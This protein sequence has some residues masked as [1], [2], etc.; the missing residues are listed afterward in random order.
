MYVTHS[1]LASYANAKVNLKRD[2]VR[3]YREQVGRLRT[4][5]EEYIDAHPDY[6][7]V[8]SLHSGS[9]GKGTALKTLNDMDVA[10]YV[11]NPR[12][13]RTKTSCSGGWRSGFEKLS[14][15]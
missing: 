10:V 4:R 8:K 13:L 6:G 12:L 1:T 2:D 9:L 3:D 5:L 15:R 14:A 11:E 7:F